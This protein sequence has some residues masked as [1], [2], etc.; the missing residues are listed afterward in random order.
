MRIALLIATL[1]LGC[2][3]KAVEQQSTTSSPQESNK[4][5]IPRGYIQTH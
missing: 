2:E 4:S 5:T 3:E 1:F